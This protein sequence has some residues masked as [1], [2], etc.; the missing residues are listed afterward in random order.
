[1]SIRWRL[2]LLNAG[3]L[4]AVLAIFSAGVF[5]FVR[6]RMSAQLDARVESELNTVAEIA[7]HTPAGLRDLESHGVA[8][9]F[10]VMAGSEVVYR[11]TAWEPVGRVRSREVEVRGRRATVTVAVD[12]GPFRDAVRTLGIVMA[13]GFPIAVALSLIGAYGL[14]G[15]MLAPVGAMASKAREISANRL[16]ERLPVVDAKDELG[17]LATVVNETLARLEASFEQLRRFTADASHELR[18][19][20]TAIRS[21]GEVAL[22]SPRD[23]AFYRDVVGSMLEEVDRLSRLVESLLLLTRAEAGAMKPKPERFDLGEAARATAE[24]LRVLADEKGQS[25]AF[26]AE[27]G[28][29]VQ[30]DPALVKQ[31]ALNLLDNA[32]KYTPSKGAVHVRVRRSGPSALV[33]VV[34]SGPGIPPEHRAR[35]FERFYRIDPSRTGDSG[36]GLGLAIAQWAI[37]ANGG[38]IEVESNGAGSTFRIVLPP[39]A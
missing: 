19:P 29:L 5:L 33:E 18:T 3:V 8:A 10:A 1:M 7:E 38:R 28:V 16:S 22:Q 6:G 31:A 30:A 39:I 11:S 12:D 20:L 17:R 15:R 32:I 14:A 9:R 37:E 23:A 24:T 36:S 34:D 21:V 27:P 35:I 2:A 4:A 26:E 25:L 13:A